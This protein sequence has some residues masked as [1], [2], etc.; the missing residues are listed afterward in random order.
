MWRQIII[1]AVFSLFSV[2]VF[3]MND[4]KVK[5][6]VEA[7]FDP[8]V[9]YSHT[10]AR[11]TDRDATGHIFKIR[12]E[13][14]NLKFLRSGDQLVFYMPEQDEKEQCEGFVRSSEFDYMKA[15]TFM[16][17]IRLSREQATVC[18]RRGSP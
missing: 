11:V 6:E 7:F 18:T 1:L 8:N 14:E 5:Q 3:S 9:D 15:R 2:K 10:V 16:I 12:G 13:D 4:A 17:G